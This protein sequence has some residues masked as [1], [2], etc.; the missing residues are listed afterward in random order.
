MSRLK[1]NILEASNLNVGID[2]DDVLNELD[3][4]KTVN[5]D[6]VDFFYQPQFIENALRRYERFWIPFL[7]E[8]SDSEYDND[9]LFAP[10][11]GNFYLPF[12]L[13]NIKITFSSW[14]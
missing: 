11:P 3:F 6:G 10:P 5:N 14:F 13:Q 8:H 12:K 2:V 1:S 9:L 4:L 7:L